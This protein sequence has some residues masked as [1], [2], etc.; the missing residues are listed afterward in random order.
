MTRLDIVATFLITIGVFIST[1][2]GTHKSPV[3]TSNEL[4][5]LYTLPPIIITIIFIIVTTTICIL[6]THY[7]TII[8][9]QCI[10]R[11]IQFPESLKIPILAYIPSALGALQIM[12]F[13]MVGELTKN[14][15]E[16]YDETYIEKEMVNTTTIQITKTR[17]VHV[18]EF[19]NPLLW[20]CLLFVITLAIGQLSYLNRGLAKYNAIKFLPTYNTLLL[21]VGVTCG[22]IYF[23]EYNAFHPVFFPIGVLFEMSGILALSWKSKDDAEKEH[24][25]KKKR[26]NNKTKKDGIT[27]GSSS[28]SD[29]DEE[30]GMKDASKNGNMKKNASS[31]PLQSIKRMIPRSH[32]KIY[33]ATTTTD[34]IINNIKNKK[35]INEDNN[36]HLLEK[37]EDDDGYDAVIVKKESKETI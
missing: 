6:F 36:N 29:E 28:S 18:N 9:N 34:N 2:T 33:P 21:M 23:Q 19:A 15:F 25:E 17:K 1:L 3:Y 24:D 5:R 27:Y 13:K 22:A 12:V 31:S 37:E 35:K 4:L 26:D 7:E 30:E 14:T 20:I 16:G 10:K 32:E 11:N 8:I